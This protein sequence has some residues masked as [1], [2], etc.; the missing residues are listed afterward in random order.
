MGIGSSDTGHLFVTDMDT[1]EVSNLNRQFLFRD[2]DVQ[3]RHTSCPMGCKASVSLTLCVCV[4]VCV[5]V[6]PCSNSSLRLP[7]AP[8]ST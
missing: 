5:S 1:I 3:V 8:S 2:K 7:R 4:C 6:C